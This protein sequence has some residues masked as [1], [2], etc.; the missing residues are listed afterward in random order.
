LRAGNS[1]SLYFAVNGQTYGPAAPGAQVVRNIV[2]S[3]EALTE[4]YTLADLTRD[5]DLARIVAL[6]EAAEP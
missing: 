3:P 1:G 5:P 6:A 4:R 2:L